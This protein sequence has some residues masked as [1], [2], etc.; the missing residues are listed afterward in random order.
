MGPL[1]TRIAPP[2]GPGRPIRLYRAV[3]PPPPGGGFASETLLRRVPARAPSTG[4]GQGSTCSRFKSGEGP[5]SSL[6]QRLQPAGPRT[7]GLATSPGTSTAGPQGPPA[8]IPGTP[9]SPLATT[10]AEAPVS[11]GRH[12][13]IA[14]PAS[15]LFA[16]KPA[17]RPGG[18]PR[19]QAWRWRRPSPWWR[20][21]QGLC[22]SQCVCAS[23]PAS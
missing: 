6:M 20:V 13:P 5:T 21:A 7:V 11:G 15:M 10:A 1:C 23:V 19:R 4:S 16:V 12:R 9:S 3:V 8:P 17:A 22:P 14:G 2:L 18:P